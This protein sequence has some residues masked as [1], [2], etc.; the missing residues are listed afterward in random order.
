M[1]YGYFDNENQEYVIDRVDLPT[2]WT[3]YLG[4]NDL[5]TVI[6]HT[7]GGYSFYKSPEYHRI[8]R[9]RANSVPMDRP[10]HYVYLRDD[11]SKDYWSISWQ[12]VGK[13]LHQANYQCCHGLSY[14]K[15]NCDYSRIEAEQK[16]FIPMDDP[17]E[18]WDVR[19][20]NNDT[21]TRY[22]SVFSYIEFSYHHIDMDNRNFQMSNYAAGSSYVDGIIEH[23]LF[24]EEF[25]Y[26]F[27]TSNFT[28]DSFDCLRDKFLGLYHTEDNPVAVM[29][30]VCSG[31]YEKGG[32]HCGSLHK[33]LELKPGEEIRLIFMLGEGNRE[34]GRRLRAKYSDLN[35]IDRAYRQMADYW[36]DK[37]NRLQINTPSEGMNTLINIWTLYQAEINIMFSRFAS[38]IEVGGRTGLGYRDTAQDAMTVIH[39]NPDK[40]RQRIMEL[41]RA[42]VS[43]GYGLHLFQPEWFDPQNDNKPFQ[44]P[45]VIPTPNKADMIHGIDQAC[46]DDALWLVSTITE[47]V[48]ETGEFSF[49]DEMI[50]YADGGSGT[51]YEH[52]MKI[53]EFSGEQ[54]GQNGICKGLRADWNDCLNLGGGESA[55]VSFLH[56]WALGNFI[57]I[58]HYLGR[59]EDVVH[60]REMQ[61]S[62]KKACDEVLWDQ[63]WYIRGITKTG[64]K[65]GTSKDAE[66]RIHLESNAWAVLSGLADQEKG[67]Q[68]MDS[69]D[70]YLYTPYGIMLNGPSYTIPDEEIG[71]VTR[72]YPGLKENGAIFSHPNPWAWAAECI[73]GRG[74]RA[75][76][77]YNA[78]CP[79]YQNDLIEI[80][81]AEPYSYCQFIMGREHT[82]FGR[83]RHPFMTGTGGWAYYSATHYILGIRPQFD[84]LTI[85]PCIPSDWEEFTV[86][87]TWRGAKYRFT[88]KNPDHVMKGVRQ[89]LLNGTAVNK[90]TVQPKGS[91]NEVTVILGDE[92]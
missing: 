17:I 19:I 53:L 16:L 7:A 36:T 78:L 79:Y 73:L 77:F 81:E 64:R 68:A 39:S 41:L 29:N 15:Y 55:M 42:L 21:K 27:F 67:E 47:Y 23:D 71:F 89:I 24:Y 83:A 13:P 11:E 70:H 4:V 69:I 5:C 63:D 57:D 60:Y 51:V 45:T 52:M 49:L 72:V 25:G 92:K 59:K 30:G 6:N 46:S 84:T 85:D 65:I 3:N 9:F 33:K 76:K 38:F 87:R 88:V 22:L 35:E 61:E 8:T 20:K 1:K 37:R 91:S 80:R 48:K 2:S 58:A 82:A 74:D 90:V 31:S 43:K 54:V 75:M 40:C 86:N 66:G 14:T 44:S 28:P 50:T 26:Q 56:Y 10:G 34:N 12:P 32:N 18:L 62:V